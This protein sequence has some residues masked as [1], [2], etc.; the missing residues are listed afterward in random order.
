MNKMLEHLDLIT[1]MIVKE[2]EKSYTDAYKD[3]ML[4]V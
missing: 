3:H 4:K 1:D 2:N